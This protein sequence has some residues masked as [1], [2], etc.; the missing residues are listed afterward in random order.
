MRRCGLGISIMSLL[1]QAGASAL[2]MAAKESRTEVVSLL[3]DAGA[4]VDI[5]NEV[6]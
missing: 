5:Q 1:T 6:M 4:Y 2:M 3:L